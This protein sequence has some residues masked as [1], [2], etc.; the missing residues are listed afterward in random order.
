MFRCFEVVPA[1]CKN[2]KEESH[3][4]YWLD[5]LKQCT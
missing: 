1:D 4:S 2:S 3:S 5:S